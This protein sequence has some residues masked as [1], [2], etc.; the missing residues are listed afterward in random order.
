MTGTLGLQPV[1]DYAPLPGRAEFVVSDGPRI[2]IFRA[3]TL[4]PLS[5]LQLGRPA[6]FLG[7]RPEAHFTVSIDV[8]RTYVVRRAYPATD[9]ATNLPPTLA[10]L[11][12]ANGAVFPFPAAMRLAAVPE[13]ADGGIQR[14]EFRRQQEVLGSVTNH[15]F[16][17]EVSTLPAG[18]H[19]LTALAIDNLGATSAPVELRLRITQRPAIR[20]VTPVE[21]AIWDAG[22]NGTL[23]VAAS[24]PDGTVLRVE[25]FR[26]TL[27]PANLLAVVTN[28]PWAVAVPGFNAT[29]T[30]YAR[31]VDND[32]VT[33]N[34]PPVLV[35]LA[36]PTGD[37]FY[38]PF[39]LAGL[40][41]TARA[42]N[43]AATAQYFESAM[44]NGASQR[45]L[46]WTWT[47][48]TNGI[49]RLSTRGSSFDT[50]LGLYTGADIAVLATVGVN[51]DELAAPPTSL[52]KFTGIAGRQYRIA[53][54]GFREAA[55]DVQLTLALETPLPTPPPNDVFAN[56]LVLAGPEVVLDGSNVAATAESGEPAHAGLAPGPSVWFEWTA[57]TNG[58]VRAGLGPVTFD[59]VL[60]VYTITGTTLNSLRALTSND[61]D[62]AGR[63]GSR[64]LFH[65]TTGTRYILAVTGYAGATGAFTLGLE[66]ILRP[67]GPPANDA[68]ARRITVEGVR[69]QVEGSNVGAT[70]EPLEPRLG[71]M[72]S[73]ATVWWNWR[74]PGWGRTYVQVV[75]GGFTA[76]VAVFTGNAVNALQQIA[77]STDSG[78]TGALE[79][80]AAAGRD[81][82]IAVDGSA[83]STGAFLLFLD[84]PAPLGPPALTLGADPGG[85][86][87]LVT[88][89]GWSGTGVILRSTDLATWEP[90]STN[91]FTPGIGVPLPA[92]HQPVEFFRLQID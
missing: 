38:R 66:Q 87:G 82:A 50:V 67:P 10:W 83:P 52:V 22:S 63:G 41:A 70:A 27:V 11:E 91:A 35:Q 42:S 90:V 72:S 47:A 33:S 28:A 14:V 56:R 20:W 60:A 84:A 12:P 9:P 19:V 30:F 89:G 17:L 39:E 80:E 21:P 65:G 85:A 31:A 2:G 55:G 58:T 88:E 18:D 29:T 44:L 4:A 6:R 23:E 79:F 78:K 13:D 37:E 92:F 54:D 57:P 7:A 69:W 5:L 59:S 25:F 1:L 62:P 16:A 61:D 81:Y 43:R 86:P 71:S 48:P 24:D 15:P 34:P 75:G 46:W 64:V 53:V 74:A 49:Y 77:I 40:N 3:D 45:T 8:G 51:N 76:R 26:E 32:G 68:F 36:G 73:R